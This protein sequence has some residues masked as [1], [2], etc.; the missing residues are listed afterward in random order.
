MT[1]QKKIPAWAVGMILTIVGV[2]FT[3]AGGLMTYVFTNLS[4]KVDDLDRSNR[5]M[6]Q[7]FR[8]FAYKIDD[9]Q[10]KLESESEGRK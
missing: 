9:F 8:I 4:S 10:K 7:E 3:V 6:G 2:L 5:L 1:E